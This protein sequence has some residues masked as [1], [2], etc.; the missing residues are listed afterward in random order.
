LALISSWLISVIVA[1]R[2]RHPALLSL[3]LVLAVA[4]VTA[5]VSMSHIFGGV[6]Y[7]LVLYAWTINAL[8][9]LAISWTLGALIGPRLALRH[10]SRATTVGALGAAVAI[11]VSI[12]L[13]AIDA[14]RIEPPLPETSEAL[15]ALVPK[16][17]AALEHRGRYLVSWNDQTALDLRGWGLFNELDRAGFDVGVP[18]LYRGAATGHRVLAASN[19]TGLVHLENGAAIDSWRS[20]PNV[21]QVAYYDPR[22]PEERREFERLRLLL[23]RDLQAAGLPQIVRSV[24]GKD[25]NDNLVLVGLNPAVPLK[26]RSTV[27]HMLHLGLPTAVFVGP[28][29]P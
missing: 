8:I 1:A 21:R 17:V 7:W 3:H 4:M 9:V 26:L 24:D 29:E 10:R 20:K 14:S 18:E 19:A 16:T 2:L 11:T 28:A 6:Q 25:D 12:V 5:A 15:S 22:T 27:D 13:F 23:V